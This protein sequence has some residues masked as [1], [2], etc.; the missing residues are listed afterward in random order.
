ME[1]VWDKYAL[2]FMVS[3]TVHALVVASMLVAMPAPKPKTTIKKPSYVQA[4]LITLDAQSQAQPAKPK[5]RIVDLTRQREEE[6]RQAAQEAQQR[7]QQAAQEQERQQVARQQQRRKQEAEQQ[8]KVAA[9]QKA[10]AERQARVETER[11]ERQETER[12]EQAEADRRQ[13]ERQ[14]Q[15]Q[16]IFEEAL[17]EEE[18]ALA[19]AEY[20]ATAQSYISVISQRIEQ[21]WSRPPSAR[22]NMQCE[23][24]IKLVPT[25]RVISVDIIRSSGND[26]FDRSAVQAVNRSEQFP[27]IREMKPEVFERYYREL[28]LVFNPQDLRQ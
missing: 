21:N 23:L 22:N 28:R 17:Q 15:Q 1:S 2:P 6:S 9:E 8:A 3:I 10:T 27:E 18:E 12:R 11:R 16:Q 14:I 26:Q 5:P 25:G 13:R 7:A 4:K 24:L 20:A 19:E